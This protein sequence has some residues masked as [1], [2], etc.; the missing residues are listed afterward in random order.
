MRHFDVAVA[1]VLFGFAQAAVAQPT[2]ATGENSKKECASV[3]DATGKQVFRC[4]PEKIFG[5]AQRPQAPYVLTQSRT[6]YELAPLDQK[7][8]PKVVEAVREKPF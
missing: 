8:A 7:L 3:R 4:G 2:A 6:G 5:Q 1:V